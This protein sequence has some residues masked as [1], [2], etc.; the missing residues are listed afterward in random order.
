MKISLPHN[1]MD[2]M[3]NQ[4]HPPLILTKFFPLRSILLSRRSRTWR[5]NAAN[6]KIHYRKRF[7][8]SSFHSQ[9]H[10][11]LQLRPT[12]LIVN[13]LL[14]LS[15]GSTLL[16]SRPP[17]GN[18]SQVVPLPTSLTCCSKQKLLN[19]WQS[20]R[21]GVIPYLSGLAVCLMKTFENI[22][23]AHVGLQHKEETATEPLRWFNPPFRMSHRL[24]Q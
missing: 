10:K 19:E 2:T 23:K 3:A 21:Y 8:C 15:Y 22:F 1:L 7:W 11:L 20:S 6:N 12:F 24:S 4:F 17:F 14:T 16:I 18:G 5:F 13:C 9:P